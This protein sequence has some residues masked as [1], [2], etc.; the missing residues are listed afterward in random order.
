MVVS[1]DFKGSRNY[2]VLEVLDGPDNCQALLFCGAVV[3]SDWMRV[4]LAQYTSL[5]FL[6]CFWANMAPSPLLEALV[7]MQNGLLEFRNT[8]M[9]GGGC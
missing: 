7:Y 2:T 1:Q 9:K 5:S 8:V 3:F 6:S 4:L